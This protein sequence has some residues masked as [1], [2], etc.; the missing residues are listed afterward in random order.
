M[1]GKYRVN[2]ESQIPLEIIPVK[3]EGYDLKKIEINVTK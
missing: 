1:A 2:F 3:P